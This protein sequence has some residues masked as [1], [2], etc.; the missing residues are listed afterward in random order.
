M[1]EDPWAGA[2]AGARRD[3]AEVSIRAILGPAQPTSGSQAFPVSDENGDR[4]YVKAPNNPQGSQILVT[5]FIVSCV[6]TLIG[7]PVCVVRP[8][9][10]PPDFEGFQVQNGPMLATGIASASRAIADVVE[11]RPHLLHRESDD[12]ARRHAGAFAIFDWCWGDDQQWLIV[13]SDEYRLYSHDH[14]FYLPPGGQHWTQDALLANVD[15]P[16]P[17][18]EPPERLDVDELERLAQVLESLDRID[19]QSI[20]AGVPASWAVSD[21]DLEALGRYLDDR[22]GGVAERMRELRAKLENV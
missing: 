13:E 17:L 16:H 4:W 9:R 2:I 3:E 22:A 6:G 20:L 10:I 7:A 18:G 12:N 5:E 14:G 1:T 21:A 15:I 19:L 11:M 8:I